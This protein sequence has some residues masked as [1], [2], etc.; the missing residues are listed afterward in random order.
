MNMQGVEVTKVEEF[1]YL[2]STMPSDGRCPTE[3]TKRI[4]AGWGGWRKV[5]GVL[6][7]RNMPA[8]ARGK[9]YPCQP[10]YVVWYG[11]CTSDKIAGK[12]NGDGGNEKVALLTRTDEKEQNQKREREGGPQRGEVW[13]KSL[14]A[15]RGTR[16]EQNAGNE[17]TWGTEGRKT[18]DTVYGHD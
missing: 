4:Q 6:R 11:D 12:E 1:K 16:G 18:K 5:T 10:S 17:T 13:R 15:G 7:D 9:I 14:R 2:G 8:P 3:V